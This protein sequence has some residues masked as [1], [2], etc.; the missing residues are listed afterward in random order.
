MDSTKDA[1][2][3]TEA[4]PYEPPRIASLGSIVELT[5]VSLKSAPG[6]DAQGPNAHSH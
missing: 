1:L 5:Q 6:S 3:A 2:E 4:R